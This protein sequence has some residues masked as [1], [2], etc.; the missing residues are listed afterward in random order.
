MV[1]AWASFIF[2]DGCED[3]VW[4]EGGQLQVDGNKIMASP[5]GACKAN[6][7]FGVACVHRGKQY[8]Y[9]LGN[10]VF[11]NPNR[12]WGRQIRLTKL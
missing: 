11:V 7:V 1:A 12:V 9:H 2:V 5:P 8:G 10:F 6:S 4:Q 3:P